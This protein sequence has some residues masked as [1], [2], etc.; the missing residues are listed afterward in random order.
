[1]TIVPS[2]SADIQ[3]WIAAL[4]ADGPAQRDSA[5][6]RL[7]LIGERAVPALLETLRSGSPTVRVQALRVLERLRAP[8]A[9][10]VILG[11]L[12]DPE[13]PVAAAAAGAAGAYESAAAVPALRSAQRSPSLEASEAAARA[14]LR[15]FSAGIEEAMEPLLA[16]AFDPAVDPRVRALALSVAD[17]LP[18]DERSAILARTGAETNLD[19]LLAS[20]PDGA[21]AVT[22]LHRALL[23]LAGSGAAPAL[24]A[25]DAA[26]IHSALAERDSRIAL[27][28]LRERLLRRPPLEAAAFL[29]AAGRV[30][31]STFVAPLA[32]LA[33]EVP[34]HTAGCLGALTAI[35]AR[36]ALKKSH[37]DV[38]A[39]PA[40]HREVLEG[41][42][43][44]ATARRRATRA[45]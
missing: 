36:H 21:A 2:R 13:A 34:A 33:A 5:I 43:S 1:M 14:L 20:L 3:K 45:R 29:A 15:L 27:Y 37:R 16:A 38:K 32:A 23:G 42:W 31:D 4:G 11:H 7:T 22:A 26:R 6:A 18:A 17:Q 19:A 9:L 25:A 41:L 12:E 8:R 28:D 10:P 30:G 39:V 35:V 24:V 44:R 40:R